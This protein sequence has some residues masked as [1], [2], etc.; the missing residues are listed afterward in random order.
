MSLS[1]RHGAD[2]AENGL[3]LVISLSPEEA[4][5]L[6]ADATLIADWVDTAMWALSLL[7]TGKNL[8]AEGGP[9]PV[10]AQTWFTVI[11]DLE[12]RLAPRL[13]GI[14]D[15]AVRTQARQGGTID[16]LALA[17]DVPRSTAGYRRKAVLDKFPGGWEQWAT[18]GG[19]QRNRAEDPDNPAKNV[20]T[21]PHR[22]QVVSTAANENL[23]G[24]LC[25]CGWKSPELT[26]NTVTAALWG[27]AHA[28]AANAAAA[29]NT[30]ADP[31]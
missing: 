26:T 3:D 29:D 1:F 21:P 8:R 17:M 4:E 13:Q 19:P 11:N 27:Q 12:N 23:L 9:T 6:D 15:A 7:R 10:T 24:A 14:V 22:T 16:D 2:A 30:A 5:V 25:A 20:P 31:S 28:D 18:S